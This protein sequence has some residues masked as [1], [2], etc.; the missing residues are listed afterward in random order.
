MTCCCGAGCWGLKG[1]WPDLTRHEGTSAGPIAP[2]PP[3]PTRPHHARRP[4]RCC[5][6]RAALRRP[7][8]IRTVR[9]GT[10]PCVGVGERP[11]SEAPPALRCPEPNLPVG[12]QAHPPCALPCAL[13]AYLNPTGIQLVIQP[14]QAWSCGRLPRT[15]PQSAASCATSGDGRARR[16]PPPAPPAPTLLRHYHTYHT[17]LM[18]LLCCCRP[19]TERPRSTTA[20]LMHPAGCLK[21]APRRCES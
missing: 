1:E 20:T 5:W 6:A 19:L 10:E 7:T 14:Q 21:S 13:P 18:G 2:C 9:E 8:S 15:T 11:G 4:P 3:A 12:R 16:P 17:C